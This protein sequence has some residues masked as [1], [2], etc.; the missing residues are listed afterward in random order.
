MKNVQPILQGA[1]PANYV[2]V[3][4]IT[5]NREDTPYCLVQV[6]LETGKLEVLAIKAAGLNDTPRVGNRVLCVSS[7]DSEVYITMLLDAGELPAPPDRLRSTGKIDARIVSQKKSDILAVYNKRNELIFEYDS[8]KDR[9]RV[10][11]DC[12]GFDLQVPRGDIKLSAGGKIQLDSHSITMTASG[13]SGAQKSIFNVGQFRVDVLSSIL[14][15]KSSHARFKLD[16]TIYE[17]KKLLSNIPEAKIIWG[18]LEVLTDSLHQKF[19]TIFTEV[20]ELSQTKA[21]RMRLL[22]KRTFRLKADRVN[23]KADKT[24]NIDGERINLG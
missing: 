23:M 4:V 3:G 12:S 10:L 15:I 14:N 7:F 17:G 16:S 22:V 20:E 24:V 9:S 13:E 5:S 6:M 1:L 18:K 21:G 2:G 11:L 8:V 19:K